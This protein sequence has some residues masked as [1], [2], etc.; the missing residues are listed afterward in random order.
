[1]I[2]RKRLR[3]WRTTPGG[4]VEEA[5]QLKT[6]KA[7]SSV[8]WRSLSSLM[9]S[10]RPEILRYTACLD[11]YACFLSPQVIWIKCTGST[12]SHIGIPFP[13]VA[14]RRKAFRREMGT[15]LGLKPGLL[16][17]IKYQVVFGL[18]GLLCTVHCAFCPFFADRFLSVSLVLAGFGDQ[19]TPQQLHMQSRYKEDLKRQVSPGLQPFCGGESLLGC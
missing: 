19:P 18:S 9:R 15:L 8:S 13:G 4:K 7:I 1:M 3:W 12:R 5:L 17:P 14:G 6:K 2:P 11:T 16:F 10:A